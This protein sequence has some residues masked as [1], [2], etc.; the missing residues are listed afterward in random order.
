MKI[1]SVDQGECPHA[2]IGLLFFVAIVLAIG[3]AA[4][5]T[6]SPTDGILA[7]LVGIPLVIHYLHRGADHLRAQAA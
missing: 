4:L 6:V 1:E 3:V 5:W 7:S 2:M